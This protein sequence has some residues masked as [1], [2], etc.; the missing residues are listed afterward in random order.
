MR[1]NPFVWGGTLV[2]CSPL[3]LLV[4]ETQHLH[5]LCFSITKSS[6]PLYKLLVWKYFPQLR[7]STSHFWKNNSCLSSQEDVKFY[8]FFSLECSTFQNFLPPN[9]ILAKICFDFKIF[10][11]CIRISLTL[12][13]Y[14]LCPPLKDSLLV[15]KVQSG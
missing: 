8:I 9:L 4:L 7:W 14:R 13:L 15:V 5:L 2:V 10:L 11:N 12:L 3:F 1:C 6:R